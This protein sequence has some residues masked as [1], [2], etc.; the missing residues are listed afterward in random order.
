MPFDIKDTAN[1][2]NGMTCEDYLD[3]VMNDASFTPES[4]GAGDSKTMFKDFV[5]NSREKKEKDANVDKE[6]SQKSAKKVRQIA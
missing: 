2:P 1:Y 4:F 6:V 3:K 5:C